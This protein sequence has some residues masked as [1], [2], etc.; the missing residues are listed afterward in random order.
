MHARFC[1]R[2]TCASTRW[3]GPAEVTKQSLPAS[4]DST[5]EVIWP[6]QYSLGD[7]AVAVSR[8]A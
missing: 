5:G 3:L 7:V 8:P 2:V 6:D 4:V 1:G